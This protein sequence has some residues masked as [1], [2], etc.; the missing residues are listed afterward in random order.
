MKVETG[1][2]K[3]RIHMIYEEIAPAGGYCRGGSFREAK[4][5]LQ[6]L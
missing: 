2:K 4:G 6:A 1:A 3:E 5:I